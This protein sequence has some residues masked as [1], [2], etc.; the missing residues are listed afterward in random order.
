MPEFKDR[1]TGKLVKIPEG[2]TTEL[3]PSKQMGSQERKANNAARK[4]VSKTSEVSALGRASTAVRKHT[5]AQHSGKY[6]DDCAKCT[7]LK[8]NLESARNAVSSREDELG[9]ERPSMTFRIVPKK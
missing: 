3:V 1:R 6:A 5:T 9:V 7:T 4:A 2:Y 8:G